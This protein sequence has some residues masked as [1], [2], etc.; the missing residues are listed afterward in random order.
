MQRDGNAESFNGN[1]HGASANVWLEL[2]R[3]DTGMQET[4]N[5]LLFYAPSMRT[6]RSLKRTN[7]QS[8]TA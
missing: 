5:S 3:F 2:E 6:L 4:P 7:P 8:T 1:H